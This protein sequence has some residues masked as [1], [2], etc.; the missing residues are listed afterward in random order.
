MNSI[1]MTRP[2]TQVSRATARCRFHFPR[3]W[4]NTQQC[5]DPVLDAGLLQHAAESPRQQLDR[6]H[7]VPAAWVLQ[8]RAGRIQ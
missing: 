3:I 8:A 4:F 5:P 6:I 7:T 1:I 2:P